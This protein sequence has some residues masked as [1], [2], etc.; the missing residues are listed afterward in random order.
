MLQNAMQRSASAPNYRDTQKWRYQVPKPDENRAPASPKVATM[1]MS[2]I[3]ANCSMDDIRNCSMNAHIVDLSMDTNNFTGNCT[4]TG[5]ITVRY[6]DP[7]MLESLQMNLLDKGIKID[8]EKPNVNRKD[9]YYGSSRVNMLNAI[10]RQKKGQPVYVGSEAK[11]RELASFGAVTEP[12]KFRGPGVKSARQ[13]AEGDKKE[14]Y[15]LEGWKEL[16]K[17]FNKPPFRSKY[18]PVLM[19]RPK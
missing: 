5:E 16:N 18:T 2:N 6:Q 14:R 7:K 13:S 10:Q 1:N 11:D 3:D 9:T 4:G 19:L 15:A 12:T 17:K 8:S